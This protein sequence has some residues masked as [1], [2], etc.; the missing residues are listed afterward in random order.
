[1]GGFAAARASTAPTFNH[2]REMKGGIPGWVGIL[3]ASFP[4]SRWKPNVGD[5]EI[6]FSEAICAIREVHRLAEHEDGS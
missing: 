2:T 6:I 3:P 5:R 4:A 1:L